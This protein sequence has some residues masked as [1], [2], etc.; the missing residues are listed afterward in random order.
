MN[1]KHRWAAL[2]ILLGTLA[3]GGS[4]A[5]VTF[6]ED[7]TGTTTN[8]NWYY[9]GGACLTAGTSTSSASPGAI[10]GCTSVLASYYHLQANADP[11]MMGGY[12]G[13][14]GSST[15]PGSVAAQAPD[16]VITTNGS[17]R[18][19]RCAGFHERFDEHQRLGDIRSR[20]ALRDSL[21]YNDVH[22]C[23]N[24]DH[25]QDRYLPR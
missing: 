21:I 24:P 3:A 10:P 4:R 16:P 23:G 9:F 18:G 7:F 17:D 12:L 19:L 14:L 6:S 15:A 5:Q 8:N 22:Q 2:C 25:L 20:R 13:Y 1:A 11:Y